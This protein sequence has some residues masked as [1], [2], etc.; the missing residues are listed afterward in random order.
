MKKY[1]APELELVRFL[2]EEIATDDETSNPGVDP[3]TQ[4]GQQ[5]TD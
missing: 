4:G 2:S 5:D 1:E 3:G